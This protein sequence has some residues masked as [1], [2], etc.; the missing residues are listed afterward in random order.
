MN[1]NNL[2]TIAKDIS[3]LADMPND[4]TYYEACV[5]VAEN[6]YD[7]DYE[8]ACKV[9]DIIQNKYLSYDY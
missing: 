1:L 3:K 5:L 2:D 7:L 9:A 4:E 6:L 8:N